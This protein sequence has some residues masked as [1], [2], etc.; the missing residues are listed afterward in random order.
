MLWFAEHCREVRNRRAG[1]AAAFGNA[2]G[3]VFIV[4]SG[5]DVITKTDSEHKR[6]EEFQKW[7]ISIQDYR[8]PCVS[9]GFFP[10]WISEESSSSLY[11]KKASQF[12]RSGTKLRRGDDDESSFSLQPASV[13]YYYLLTALR[14][15]PFWPSSS[16]SLSLSLSLFFFHFVI[17][18]RSVYLGV[19]VIHQFHVLYPSPLARHRCTIL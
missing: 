8:S 6:R 17:S 18:Y 2:A 1:I 9:M 5:V 13:T 12:P 16:F 4:R 14:I 3:T 15:S 11:R 7:A 10:Q 19:G